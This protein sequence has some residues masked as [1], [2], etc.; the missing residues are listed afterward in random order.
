[1]ARGNGAARR[2]ALVLGL[3]AVLAALPAVIGALPAADDDRTAVE[4]R[5]AALGS[6]GV[7]FSGYAQSS[8]GLALP[9]TEQLDT[10]ADL[11]SDRTSMRVWWRGPTDH[12]VDVV[13]AGGETGLHRDATG[14]WR[15]EYEPDRATRIDAEPLALPVATDLL[16]HSL[17]RR[18]LSEARA[19]ELSRLPARRVAG[20]DAL[21]LRLTPADIA[22][23]VTRVDCWIDSSTGLPLAVQVWGPDPAVPALDTR[24]LDLD[25]AVPDRSLTAFA[26][27]IDASRERSDPLGALNNAAADR[28]GFVLPDTLAGLPRRSLAGAPA[29]IALYG[30]GVTLL[31]VVP[32]P[33]RVARD[34]RD[35]AAADPTAV[36]DDDGTRL[37]V[38]PLG[39]LLAGTSG[40]TSYALIGTVTGDALVEAARALPGLRDAP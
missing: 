33:G 22:A 14:S 16:P 10:V 13:T 25:L 21:G 7:G 2:W 1:M 38:G 4:L 24:F 40:R 34:L 6:V 11:F 39:I 12:R 5:T 18:L 9:E 3:V 28:P 23:A 31:A 8:G 29:G 35:A 30:R 17:A 37:A 15:W 27:P 32:L 20:R 36:R 26:P 19:D